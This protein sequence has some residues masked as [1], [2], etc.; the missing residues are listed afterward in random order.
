MLNKVCSI[1]MHRAQETGIG[2]L[3]DLDD[4]NGLIVSAGP[5][6]EWSLADF[7]IGRPLGKGT[8]LLTS[9]TR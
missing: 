5:S 3:T 1:R 7:E 2:K 8:Y 6:K 4:G 9:L